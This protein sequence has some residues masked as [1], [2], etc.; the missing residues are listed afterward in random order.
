[1]PEHSWVHESSMPQ[2]V[3]QC[4]LLFFLSCMQLLTAVF[5]ILPL[6]ELCK[7]LEQLSETRLCTAAI[8]AIFSK[9]KIIESARVVGSGQERNLFA[10]VSSFCFDTCSHHNY[11]SIINVSILSMCHINCVFFLISFQPS[12]VL[13]ST[14]LHM[15]WCVLQIRQ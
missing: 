2:Q 5:W 14:T 7:L 3:L 15:A 12:F 9:D 4:F 11:L 8:Q 13:S 6:M 10:S 1:M